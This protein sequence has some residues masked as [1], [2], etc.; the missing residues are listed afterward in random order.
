MHRYKLVSQFSFLPK[1]S[2]TFGF[3]QDYD[4]L[5][6]AETAVHDASCHDASYHDASAMTVSFILLPAET[7]FCFLLRLSRKLNKADSHDRKPIF[8][9]SCLGRKQEIADSLH[10]SPV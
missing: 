8:V 6:P 1:L 4:L 5:L 3:C 7:L 9:D 10:R 2:I